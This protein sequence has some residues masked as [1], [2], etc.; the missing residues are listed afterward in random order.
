MDSSPVQDSGFFLKARQHDVASLVQSIHDFTGKPVVLYFD[1]ATQI[2]NLNHPVET[3]EDLKAVM[4]KNLKCEVII[5]DEG[6]AIGPIAPHYVEYQF[7]L[8]SSSTR[9]SS[10][11]QL[12]FGSYPRTTIFSFPTPTYCVPTNLSYATDEGVTVHPM[13]RLA[14]LCIIGNNFSFESSFNLIAA[15]VAGR[16]TEEEDWFYL[17]PEPEAVLRRMGNVLERFPVSRDLSS[18]EDWYVRYLLTSSLITIQIG[19]DGLDD[20]FSQAPGAHHEKWDLTTLDQD[21]Q[22]LANEYITLMGPLIKEYLPNGTRDAASVNIMLSP[23]GIVSIEVFRQ[24]GQRIV[25]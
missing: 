8:W 4:R 19:E 21:L 18:S 16:L 1:E 20:F 14:Q 24:D 15:A 22:K 3:L 11:K 9:I 2:P 12:D 7:N 25:F 13:Y 10:A 6:I 5:M 23:F 17:A